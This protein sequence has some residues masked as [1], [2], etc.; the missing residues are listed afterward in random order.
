MTTIA[1]A[2][3]AWLTQRGVRGDCPMCGHERWTPGNAILT[4]GY[5][6]VVSVTC[7]QCQYLMLFEA[8]LIDLPDPDEVG[9]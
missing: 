2:V 7:V 4:V 6:P 3:H 5:L 8:T 9:G 1:E